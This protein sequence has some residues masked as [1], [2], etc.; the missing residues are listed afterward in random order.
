[1]R[2]IG[3][4]TTADGRR[5]GS[6]SGGG[7]GPKF[8]S[9]SSVGERAAKTPAGRVARN[10]ASSLESA[11]SIA[12]EAKF[13]CSLPCRCFAVVEVHC[14]S[15]QTKLALPDSAAGKRALCPSCQSEF[16]VP[17]AEASENLYGREASSPPNES[18]PAGGP[19]TGAA[20]EPP[21]PPW[22]PRPEPVS[23]APLNPYAPSAGTPD[24][25]RPIPQRSPYELPGT[26]LAVFSGIGLA[27][28]GLYTVFLVFV[29]GVMGG[30]AGVAPADI[31]VNVIGTALSTASHLAALVGGIEMVRRRR[32]GLARLGAWAGLYPCGSCL[33]LP[34]PIAVWALVVLY[35]GTA[36]YDFSE[37]AAS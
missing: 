29:M 33:I 4:M 11:G 18:E 8:T 17:V 27:I 26:L 19:L 2:T 1:M 7:D 25:A 22:Q 21:V 37:P 10:A 14:P 5:T 9:G 31:A 35:S 15:C 34:L 23:D 13:V 3:S 24:Q 28:T 30:I 20:V 12:Y 32:L 6:R 16:R 36:Q